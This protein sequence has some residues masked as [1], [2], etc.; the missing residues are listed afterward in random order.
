M[1][2]DSSL[3]VPRNTYD[4]IE[5][6]QTQIKCL[7]MN[8]ADAAFSMYMAVQHFEPG[9]VTWWWLAYDSL[10]A[11]AALWGCL[12]PPKEYFE[13]QFSGDNL[14]CQ[15]AQVAGQ[16][17]VEFNDPSGNRVREAQSEPGQAKNIQSTGSSDGYLSCT[18]D[19]V[20][21]VINI[22]QIPAT[23]KSRP[24]WFIV[25]NKGTQCCLG[26]P[27]IPPTQPYPL[28][29]EFGD[30][31][32]LCG[33]QVKLIDSCIDK[34]GLVQNFY[35]VREDFRN[36]D[37]SINVYFYWESVRGPYIYNFGGLA[38]S[39]WGI[40]SRPYY[41]PPHPDADPCPCSSSSPTNEKP[42][43]EGSWVT[44]RWISDQKMEHSGRRL[45]KLFR[46][47]SKGGRFLPELTAW[48]TN[49]QWEAGDTL[50]IHKDAWWGTPQVWARDA[51]EGKRVIRFAGSEAGIDPDKDGQWAVSSSSSPRYGMSGTMKVHLKEGF[52]W[53]ASRPGPN[54]PNYLA[55]PVDP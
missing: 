7:A 32:N 30:Y 13:E 27:T 4:W 25:P 22:K 26:S 16:L 23:G 33:T 24:I 42:V 43:L 40:N 41:A 31:E 15:C 29:Y 28:P 9:G 36:C 55:Q 3:A 48:W 2:E 38:T 1:T 44:T 35:Q 50:V 10:L 12:A 14:K 51:E 20:D 45:R 52:P 39:W 18:W 46:Y 47:R 34:F 53:I 8:G 37:G 11:T 19:M 6:N 5:A 54:F 17:F 49:F 21:G